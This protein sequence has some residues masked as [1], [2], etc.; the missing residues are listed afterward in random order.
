MDKRGSVKL[1]MSFKRYFSLRNILI[2]CIA[3]FI[4][5]AIWIFFSLPEVSEIKNKNPQTTALIEHR[6][7]QALEAGKKLFVRQKWVRFAEIPELLKKA[8]RITEDA[9]FYEHNGIDWN[10]LKESIKKNIEQ[11]EYSRGGSTISQQ[12]AKN[13][14]LSNE[15]SLLRK[16]KEYFITQ[17]IENEVSKNRIFHLYLNIIEFGP[18]VFGVGAASEYYFKKNIQDLTLGEIV[19]LTA[20][21]PRPLT[22]KANGNSKWLKWKARWILDKMKLYKYIDSFTH[23]RAKREFE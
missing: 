2:F 19:R 22:I 10:E 5:S 21:I 14:Y 13:L 23:R 7:K 20:V 6:K 18:G 9:G 17:R 3:L 15:K 8:V 12:L 16:F 11:G 4:F 1:I